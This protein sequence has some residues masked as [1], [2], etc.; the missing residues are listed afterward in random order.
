MDFTYDDYKLALTSAGEAKLMDLSYNWDKKL[1]HREYNK[2]LVDDNS[3]TSEKLLAMMVIANSYLDTN[4]FL[5]L[6][7]H[8]SVDASV[9]G[10]W[11]NADELNGPLIRKQFYLSM[12]KRHSDIAPDRFVSRA[13]EQYDTDI[14]VA[15]LK[16]ETMTKRMSLHDKVELLRSN[17]ENSNFT[18]RIVGTSHLVEEFSKVYELHQVEIYLSDEVK[19]IFLF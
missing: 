16:N 18:D 13:L 12:I 6:L 4:L 15:M 14:W 9:I 8:K 19:D 5:G 3:I 2:Q 11:L 17:K 7:R 10:Y 1:S